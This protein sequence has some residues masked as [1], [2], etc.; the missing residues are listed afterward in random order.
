M[1]CIER[2]RSCLPSPLCAGIL[3]AALPNEDRAISGLFSGVVGV[4]VAVDVSRGAANN[5]SSSS[6]CLSFVVVGVLLVVVVCLSVVG[7]S[8]VNSSSFKSS[9]VV[10]S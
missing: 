1:T 10:V 8:V 9:N 5:N 7:L 6:K 3:G 2:D 4:V